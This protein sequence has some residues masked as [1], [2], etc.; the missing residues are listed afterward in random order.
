MSRDRWISFDCYGT[1]IDWRTGLLAACETAAPEYGAAMLDRHREVEGEIEAG[2]WQPYRA[3]LAQSLAEM[4]RRVGT[5]VR[6]GQADAL[7]TSLPQWPFYPDTE[8]GLSELRAD[9]WR[10]AILSNVD[11]D[12]MAL[13][14]TRFPVEIDEIVTAESI[15]S[16]K[17]APAHFEALLSRTGLDPRR[18]VHA[19][20]N[21]EYDLVPAAGFGAMTVWVNREREPEVDAPVTAVVPDVGRVPAA[22]R[23]LVPA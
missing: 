2:P 4:A 19:A 1:L 7:A 17:P 12:L 16:Y 14:R 15:R 10:I 3:V 11:D 23:D 13:T 21:L 20:V 8:P 6:P 18:W 9:G 22:V 5:T